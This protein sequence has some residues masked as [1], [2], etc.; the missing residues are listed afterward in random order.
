M[1]A[2]EYYDTYLY[3]GDTAIKDLGQDAT[4]LRATHN[5][6]KERINSEYPKYCN[7]YQTVF[8]DLIGSYR[9]TNL[10][11]REDEAPDYFNE[12]P[13]LEWDRDNRDE[14][15]LGLNTKID[16]IS[17]DLQ[18]KTEQWSRERQELENIKIEFLND[19]RK[20]DSIS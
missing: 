5:F 8:A 19:L 17:T 3:R 6:V 2:N 18:V 16:K 12:D 4:T 20:Y 11:T 1:N 7:Y 10:E 13:V 15:L 9:N 14:Q